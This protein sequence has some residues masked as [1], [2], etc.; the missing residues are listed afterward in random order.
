MAEVGE[1]KTTLR[2]GDAVIVPA[3]AAHRFTN[4]S[5]SP[6]LTFNVYCPPAYDPDEAG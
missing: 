2:K 6:A 1:E 4:H 5:G 3:G